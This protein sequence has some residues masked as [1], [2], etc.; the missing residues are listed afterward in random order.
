MRKF[1]RADS[2]TSVVGSGISAA[3]SGFFASAGRD[4]KCARARSILTSSSSRYVSG[5]TATSRRARTVCHCHAPR[6]RRA[7]DARRCVL[8]SSLHAG[9]A[10][11][12]RRA[13]PAVPRPTLPAKK[14]RVD[15]QRCVEARTGARAFI[16]TVT[17]PPEDTRARL[18]LLP[19]APR[20]GFR[21]PIVCLSSAVFDE[22]WHRN[23]LVE[24]YFSVMTRNTTCTLRTLPCPLAS[25]PARHRRGSSRLRAVSIRLALLTPARTPAWGAPSRPGFAVSPTRSA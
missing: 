13:S 9:S 11:P 6:P 14:L 19:G 20:V 10:P 17:R 5:R 4:W 22:A 2:N 23:P 8:W 12:P 15:A 3:P 16:S 21:E 18:G 25:S 1:W 24:N 7:G